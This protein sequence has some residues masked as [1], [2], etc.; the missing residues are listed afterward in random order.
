MMERKDIFDVGDGVI[1][2]GFGMSV[3][4]IVTEVKVETPENAEQ[5][6][7]GGILTRIRRHL[8][9]AP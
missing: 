6:D 2:R 7:G 1:Y 5:G 3:A 4:G 9:R 8:E